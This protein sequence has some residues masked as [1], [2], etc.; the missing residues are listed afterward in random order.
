MS[1][2]QSQLVQPANLACPE[3]GAAMIRRPSRY[4][5][6]YGCIRYP[7]C[8]STHG[9]HPNGAPLGIP[10]DPETKRAR[11]R[12]HDAFD[13]LWKTKRMTRQQGYLWLRRVMRM[14]KEEGHI[15]R[16]TV[17]QCEE[18]LRHCETARKP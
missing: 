17:A 13:A 14:S 18:L 12:A 4:G 1:R 15:G 7:E 5:L 16:F 9:C 2:P 8:R 10:G 6:F 3:C 11:M